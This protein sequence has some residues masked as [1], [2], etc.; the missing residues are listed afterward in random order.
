MAKCGYDNC[1]DVATGNCE[2]CR[3][4]ICSRHIVRTGSFGVGRKCPDCAYKQPRKSGCFIATATYGTPSAQEV[5]ILRCWR[6]NFLS[7]SKFG[8]FFIKFYYSISPPIAVII[9]KSEALKSFVRFSLNP[10]I[11]HLKK[12]KNKI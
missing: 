11:R 12:N 1:H 10:V 9:S 5:N 2:D 8:R 3:R 4:P 6:D 7:R